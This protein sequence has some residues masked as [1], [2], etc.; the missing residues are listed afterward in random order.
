MPRW[1]RARAAW[2]EAGRETAPYQAGGFWYSLADESEAKLR[3]YVVEYLEI[4]GRDVAEAVA[5][6]MTRNTPEAVREG[7]ENMHAAGCEECYMVA[8]THEISEIERLIP[9]L[10]GLD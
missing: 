6:T 4:G 8:A 2:A 1:F 7:L 10:E 3:K 9:L 5:K